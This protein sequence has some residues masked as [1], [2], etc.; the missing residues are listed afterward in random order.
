MR[1]IPHA[2]LQVLERCGHLPMLEQPGAFNGAVG[3]FLRVALAAP[4]R[5]RGRVAGVV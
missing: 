4:R 3:E 5:R 2:R 1:R